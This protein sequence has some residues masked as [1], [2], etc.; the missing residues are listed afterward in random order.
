M[1]IDILKEEERVSLEL[2]SLYKRYGYLPYKMS[3]FEEYD[4][5]VANKEFLVGEGVITFTDTDGKLMALKPDV[6]LSIIKN[7]EDSEGKRKVYYN[8]NVYRISA[9]TKQ[10]KEIMQVGLECL[11]D[12]DLYDVYE[13]ICLAAESLA[14]ISENYLLNLSH[15]GIVSA[16]L[17]E[18]NGGDIFNGQIMRLLG[19]KN[20]HGAIELCGKYGVSEQ[21][22]QKLLALISAYGDM[23]TTLTRVA[24]LCA[25]DAAICA[26]KKLQ[27]LCDMLSKTKYAD[28]IRLD[29][30]ACGDMNYY[31]DILFNGFIEGIG[32]S[33]L[34]G[35]RYD[36][37]LSRM[38]RKSGA[39][40]F[41]VYLDLLEGFGEEKSQTDVDVLILY[42]ET[43]N[44][45]ALTAQVE[46]LLQ[47]GKSVR[48]QKQTGNIRY[49]ELIDL[50]GGEI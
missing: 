31:D 10:F 32:E 18:I 17:Q 49:C 48:A 50:T 25:S 39:I 26:F 12:I 6:T 2:R 38:G 7:D 47:A 13:T 8:E 37:L 14:K 22:A 19:E 16:I 5:Y 40:G 9:K 3:K 44:Y 36:K 15:L 33:V 35:G 27:T 34:S 21:G 43:T 24:A 30:S 42:N 29:F 11:G 46:N 4:L 20:A 41:A 23:Q 28:K 45:Q 1:F